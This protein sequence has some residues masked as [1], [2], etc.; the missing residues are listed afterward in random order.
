MPIRTH[1]L[2][3][4]IGKK[5]QTGTGLPGTT[6]AQLQAALSA[7]DLVSPLINAFNAPVPQ[8]NKEDNAMFYG[9]GHEWVTQTFPTSIDAPWEWPCPFLSSQAFALVTAFAMGRTTETSPAAGAHQYVSSPMD[10]VVD[11]VNLPA[12]TIVAGLRQGTAGEALDQALVGCVCIG[13]TLKLQ[14]GPGLQNSSLVSRWLGSGKF[15]QNSGLTIPSPLTEIRLGAGATTTLLINGVDY[16]ANSRFVEIEFTWDSGLVPN[17]GYFVGS[18][19]Q[20]GFDIRGRMRYGDRKIGLVFSA[21]LESDSTE[22]SD[23]LASTQG[24]VH[25]VVTGPLITGSTFH[26]AEILIPLTEHKALSYGDVNGFTTV[27]VTTDVKFD[28]SLGPIIFTGITDE[29]SILANA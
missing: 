5:K 15:I 17:A 24:S 6:A 18:G 23:L 26:Q 22:L 29:A 11:G 27:Q 21:E 8:F 28:G 7:G 14:S 3:I 10:P 9:K 12:T 13:F 19:S 25:L 4:A 2:K 1:E 20:V 16:L